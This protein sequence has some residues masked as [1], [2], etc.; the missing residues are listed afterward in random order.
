MIS[1]VGYLDVLVPPRIIEEETSS[2]AIVDERS[3]L[4]IYCKAS[5]MQSVS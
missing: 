5:G 3:K 1:Q 2:D 4:S